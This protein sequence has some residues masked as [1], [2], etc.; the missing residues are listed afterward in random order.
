MKTLGKAALEA[1]T[2]IQIRK[3]N[4]V[5]LPSREQPL[6]VVDFGKIEDL[7]KRDFDVQENNKPIFV[8]IYDKDGNYIKDEYDERMIGL[9]LKSLTEVDT[10][11]LDAIKRPAG[12]SNTIY[13]IARLSAHMRNTKGEDGFQTI[14]E[15]L[16]Y[17]MRDISEWALIKTCEFFRKSG[18][19]FF[20]TAKEF[21]DQ[22]NIFDKAA[23]NAE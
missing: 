17:D 15:D 9:N 14:L 7:I 13:H 6:S 5:S 16:A 20:P 1:I 4:E 23:K 3:P 8:A 22:A 11:M 19:P 12:T 10:K 2:N 21:T 18:K